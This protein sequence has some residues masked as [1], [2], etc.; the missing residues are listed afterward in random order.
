MSASAARASAQQGHFVRRLAASSLFMQLGFQA[1]Y[2]VGIIGC[3]T[4]V[5]G[6]DALGVSALVFALNVL[7]VVG[8]LAAGPAVDRLG[9]RR[10]LAAT[11][12]AAAALGAAGWL[13][14]LGLGL[15]LVVAA[16]HGLLLSVGTTAVDAYPR[17]LT[18]DP[19]VLM[20]ANSL[21][22]TATGV[23]VI[24]G[25]ALGA[26][27]TGFAS[28]QAVFAVLALAPLVSLVLVA[29][30]AEG[31]KPSEAPGAAHADADPRGLPA[32]LS[33]A[34]EGV[35]IT[36]SH[37]DLRLLLTVAFL[38]FF[39]YGAFDSLESLF[40]R[41]VLH[42]SAE[43]MG[44]LS[45]V[46]GVGATLGSLAVMR[47]GARRLNVRLMC[48][49]LLVTG[50]GSMLYVGTGDVRV[51]VVGQLVTGL[52]F[53]AMGPVRT[54]LVQRGCDVAHVGRVIAFMRV[55]LNSAGVLPL[56]VAPSLADAFGVQAVLFGASSFVAV[57]AALFVALASPRDGGRR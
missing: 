32:L 49:L 54:T 52:G 16:L 18:D 46:G 6:T 38:G 43:W 25:P 36:L 30:L 2:F 35:R 19:A 53:G 40:Y 20:R 14:P 28:Q 41:D 44:W 15:L 34:L 56:L 22:N 47:V 55:G 10:T 3:A 29:G 42:A 45:M 9:P 17:H 4:Y 31:G 50:V 48:A 39:A 12:V 33:D 26:L 27:I 1:T 24:L 51:V 23:A 7:L 13:L 57:V 8:G 11:F 5:L 37:P 21:T